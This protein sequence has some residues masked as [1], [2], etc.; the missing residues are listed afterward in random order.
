MLAYSA[1]EARL[2]CSAGSNTQRAMQ[3]FVT[4]PPAICAGNRSEQ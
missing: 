3:T 2:Q 4:I 1:D